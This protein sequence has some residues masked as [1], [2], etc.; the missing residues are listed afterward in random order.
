MSD[1]TGTVP[2]G[3]IEAVGMPLS[4]GLVVSMLASVCSEFPVSTDDT[5]GLSFWPADDRERFVERVRSDLNDLRAW[6]DAVEAILPA[7]ST[8]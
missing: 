4:V 5:E 8:S 3:A 7:E 6:A 2:E 1:V